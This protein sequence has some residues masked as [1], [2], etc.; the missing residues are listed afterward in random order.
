MVRH[1][2]HSNKFLKQTDLLHLLQINFADIR[3]GKSIEKERE[4]KKM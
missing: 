4:R 2:E 3:P 1:N